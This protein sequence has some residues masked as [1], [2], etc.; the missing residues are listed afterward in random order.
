MRI[1]IDRQA[2]SLGTFLVRVVLI[3][4]FSFTSALFASAS[5]SA[6]PLWLEIPRDLPVGGLIASAALRNYAP[7]L[8]VMFEVIRREPS[9]F[10]VRVLLRAIVILG[11][12]AQA[13]AESDDSTVP[14]AGDRAATRGPSIIRG[15]I[16]CGF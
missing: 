8:Y 2:A 14:K 4:A 1:V 5:L 13:R 10:Q 7:Y 12:V 9:R 16:V 11:A 6:E 3:V 15:V